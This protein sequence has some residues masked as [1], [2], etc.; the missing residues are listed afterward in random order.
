M[1]RGSSGSHFEEPVHN[2]IALWEHCAMY[3]YAV[4]RI[5]IYAVCSVTIM[6]CKDVE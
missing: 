6:C 5:V 3:N 1:R 2:C 4:D